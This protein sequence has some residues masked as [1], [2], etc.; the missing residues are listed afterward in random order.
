MK[1]TIVGRGTAG[2]IAA[3][4]FRRWSDYEIEIIGDPEIPPLT[5]GEG[6]VLELPELLAE[7]YN[8]SHLDMD[9]VGATQKHGIHYDGWGESKDFVHLFLLGVYAIHF[10]SSKLREYIESNL[11]NVTFTDNHIDDIETVDGD[12]VMD[13]RGWGWENENLRVPIEAPINSAVIVDREPVERPTTLAKAMKN[14]WMFG[15][16]LQHRMSYGY[17]YNDKFATEEEILEEMLEVVGEGSPHRSMWI[18]SYYTGGQEAGRIIRNGNASHFFEPLEATSLWAVDSV[19]RMAFDVWHPERQF[20]SVLFST[21]YENLLMETE[22]VINMH[23]LK[24]SVH[25]TEFWN[26]AK[27]IAE[28]TMSTLPLRYLL[29]FRAILDKTLKPQARELLLAGWP[30]YSIEQNFKGIGVTLEDVERW[31][32]KTPN[33]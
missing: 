10:D 3:S 1:L 17:L 30:I 12:F 19:N 4:H 22:A 27:K 18:P 24:G 31:M 32:E 11:P 6:S 33:R 23:Y 15:I 2:L 29:T 20:E 25:E 9:A 13:C 21:A 8:F 5:V 26:H 28:E 7:F 16:P 14:G